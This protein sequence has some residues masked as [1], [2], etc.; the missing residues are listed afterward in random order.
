[1][2]GDL[3]VGTSG[4]HYLHWRGIFYPAGMSPEEFLPF[5]GAHFD[6]VELNN[7]FYQ[8]PARENFEVWSGKV[9]PGFTFSVKASRYITHRK[10]L[11]DPEQSLSRLLGNASGL[12]AKLGPVLFQLPPHWRANP[13]RLSDFVHTLLPP[14]RYV[15][16]FRDP[17][18][19][20]EEIYGILRQAG[21]ALCVASSPNFPEERRITADFLFLRFH[22]GKELYGSNYSRTELG[23]WAQWVKPSLERGMD[24]YAYF[25][26]DANGYAVSN[27]ME[28]RNLFTAP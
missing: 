21:C 7:T 26:N 16:E 24:I 6:T 23:E 5:Y 9:P 19:F 22:G 27:A 12:G 25:N 1:M 8:L 17:S 13:A 14:N 18:W 4:W 15:F 2:P 3:W 11:K 10:K 28:F 20:T